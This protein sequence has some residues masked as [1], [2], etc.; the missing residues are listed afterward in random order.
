MWGQT[1]SDPQLYTIYFILYQLQILK[2]FRMRTVWS[3]CRNGNFVKEVKC[4]RFIYRLM[5]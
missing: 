2:S 4:S 3:S 5:E 1:I